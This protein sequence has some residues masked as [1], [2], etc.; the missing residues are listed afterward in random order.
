MLLRKRRRLSKWQQVPLKHPTTG[1]EGG[2][3][4]FLSVSEGPIIF[5]SWELSFFFEFTPCMIVQKTSL[6]TTS[7]NIVLLVFLTQPKKGGQDGEN[8]VHFFRVMIIMCVFLREK[9]CRFCSS[10]WGLS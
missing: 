8:D 4:V 9:S 6:L 7:Y 10:S 5:E 2:E 3:E 1:E